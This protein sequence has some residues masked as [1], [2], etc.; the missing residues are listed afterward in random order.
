[1][2]KIFNQVQS[3]KVKKSAFDLSHERKLSCNMGDLVP[4]LLQ[5]VVPGDKF[6]ITSEVMV[7]LAPMLAPVMHRMNAYIH[8]FY[9]P[10][11]ITWSGWEDFI[12]NETET[13][14]PTLGANYF[15]VVEGSIMDHL[16]LPV[17]N[18]TASLDK[19]SLLP[20]YAYMAIWNEY[21]RDENLQDEL[22]LT[23]IGVANIR[24]LLLKRNYEKD[25]FTSCLPWAQKG[26]AVEL[27]IELEPNY[28]EF[29]ASIAYRAADGTTPEANLTNF[30]TNA[31]G[32]IKDDTGTDA[33][34]IQNMSS[35]DGTVDI[36][37][38][39]TATRLQRWLERNA[40]AGTRYVEH[41]L[42]HFGV[43]SSD[44]RIQRPE[45]L[46][47]GVTPIVV[48]EVLNTNAATVSNEDLG[49]MGGH[50]ISVGQT[51]NATKYCE[52][53]GYI[54][55][56]LSIIPKTGYSQGVPKHFSR[57]TN[58]DF[59][60]PE[61]AQL[62]EQE[63]KLRELY[64]TADGNDNDQTFGYQSRF[65]EYKNQMSSVHGDF[66]TSLNFWHMVRDFSA[67]PALNEDFIQCD[68]ARD[69]LTRIFATELGEHFW[70][71]IYHKITAIRP[72]PYFNNP[73]L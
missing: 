26:G 4:I 35:V 31:I 21:Y 52:E 54:M 25:Y 11:R 43:R 18:W 5:E 33:I 47:G 49:Y 40:R 60:W 32:Q 73:T 61:F 64:M 16:G 6:T 55:G 22:N 24:T 7:R 12:T 15:N 62:G 57:S 2:A 10:N 36:N 68:E 48:S 69:D 37:D 71:Q 72:M 17:G 53:H 44:A 27:P 14:I 20:F 29:G 70:I 67:E 8:Y 13:T 59:Y 65:A 50:G 30:T 58:L 38:L 23:E 34:S 1:M 9:V 42:S 19:I 56:L 63:V 66:R 45:Y 46:G 39:R 51:N 28:S 41:L 3:A